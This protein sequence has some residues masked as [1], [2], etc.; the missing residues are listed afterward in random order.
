MKFKYFG[1]CNNLHVSHSFVPKNLQLG[2][3]SLFNSFE[4]LF[5]LYMFYIISIAN[6]KKPDNTDILLICSQEYT[7]WKIWKLCE[8]QSYT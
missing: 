5:L 6:K 3:N 7:T 8:G 2:N 1:L 4:R